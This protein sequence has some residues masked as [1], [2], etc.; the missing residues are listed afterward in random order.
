MAQRQRGQYALRRRRDDQHLR[1]TGQEGAHRGAA[2]AVA[3]LRSDENGPMPATLVMARI[4]HNSG[5]WYRASTR[6]CAAMYEP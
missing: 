3:V 6:D 5:S 2:G 4:H 1:G